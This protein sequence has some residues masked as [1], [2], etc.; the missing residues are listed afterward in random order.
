MFAF[1]ELGKSVEFRFLILFDSKASFQE[2]DYAV[3][4]KSVDFNL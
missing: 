3:L 4:T 2:F 1:A